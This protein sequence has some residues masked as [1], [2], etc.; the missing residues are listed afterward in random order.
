MNLG[1]K[2]Y[3]IDGSFIHS[4]FPAFRKGLQHHLF[5]RAYSGI[6]SP[7]TDTTL[8]DVTLSTNVTP[9]RYTLLSSLYPWLEWSGDLGIKPA[10]IPSTLPSF[11]W[12]LTGLVKN[13]LLTTCGFTTNRVLLIH[14][15]WVP[16]ISPDPHQNSRLH[17]GTGVN[18]LLLTYLLTYTLRLGNC[19]TW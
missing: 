5:T 9:A 8:C 15:S 10:L 14:S 3:W 19:Y 7:S 6:S 2:L 17:T 16:M 11:H 13:T 1:V 4:R 12:P 18:V